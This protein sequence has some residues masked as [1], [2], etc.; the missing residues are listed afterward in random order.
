MCRMFGMA[1]ARP[2]SARD[3][4]RDAP[5]GMRALAHEHADGWGIAVHAH[6]GWL[7]HRST[8]CAARCQRYDELAACVEG[9]LVIA[10]VRKKTVGETSLVNTHPFQ[11]DRFVFAHNGTVR[12]VHALVARTS[13]EQLA[14]IEGDTDSERL[15]AF[16]LTFIEALG[17]V[18]RG[19][20]AAVRALHSLGDIGTANFLFSDGV[21]LYAHRLGQSLFT[22]ARDGV[23]MIASE[24]LTD[25]RWIELAE[26]TL[27]VL[28]PTETELPLR[29][30]G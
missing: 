24:P 27:V 16:V 11:R 28:A 4:L 8:N 29:R 21:Q 17:D 25:E 18:R 3:V 7:V 6:A 23:Q 10:H 15:F 14:R 13:P 19:V 30:A 22:L 9:Q 26:R 1:A 5:R 12:D 20:T 2:V